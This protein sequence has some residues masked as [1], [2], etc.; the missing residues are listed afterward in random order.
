[1]KFVA[2]PVEVDAFK[3]EK[4]TPLEGVTHGAFA[5]LLEDGREVIT[6]CEMA[7]RM[8]P[9]P[10]DYWVIQADGYVYLNPRAVFER[11]YSLLEEKSS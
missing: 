10:G 9:A 11:K 6:T 3:I 8:T 7:A 1:M 4:V 2:N 5:L